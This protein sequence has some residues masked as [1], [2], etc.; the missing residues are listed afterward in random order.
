MSLGSRFFDM[1]KAYDP[2]LAALAHQAGKDLGLE[3]R[4]GVYA[5]FTGPSFETPAEIRMARVLGANARWACPLSP[6]S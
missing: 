6:R 4:Q 1:T 5:W 2:G 3:L